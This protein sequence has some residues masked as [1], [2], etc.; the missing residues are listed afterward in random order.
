[1]DI[2]AANPLNKKRVMTLHSD[3][4]ADL[5]PLFEKNPEAKTLVEWAPF[6]VVVNDD[7]ILGVFDPRFYRNGESFLF[8][9]IEKN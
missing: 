6:V 2:I 4:D 3:I 9:S 8:E 5:Q 1:M 7:K